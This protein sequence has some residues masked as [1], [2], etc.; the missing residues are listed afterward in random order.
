MNGFRRNLSNDVEALREIVSSIVLDEDYEKR[1]LVDAM[2]EIIKSSNV[3]NCVY[4]E[5]DPNFIDMSNVE[6]NHLEI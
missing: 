6:V 3:I 4:S 1:D 5:D 2:N